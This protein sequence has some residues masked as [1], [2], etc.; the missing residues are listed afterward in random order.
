MIQPDDIRRKA[1]DLYRQYVQAWLKGDDEFFPRAIRGRKT[2]RS[3][4]LSAASRS[5]RC[6]RAGSKETVGFGYSVEWREVN[7]RRFGRNQFPVRI[8]FETPEDLLRFLDRKA[9]FDSFADAASRLR[10]DFPVLDSWIRVN[11][12]TVVELAQDLHGLLQVLHWFRDNPRP[13][14]YARELP[15]PVET[16]FIERHQRVLREWFDLVLPPHMIRSDEEHFERRY[17]L[18]YPEPHLLVRFLD[19]QLQVDMGFPCCELS[20]PLHTLAQL[21]APIG[22]VFIVENKVNLLTLPRF[23][24]AIALGGL[25]NGVTL[26]R[27]VP[28]LE[29]TPIRY[30]GDIDVEGFMILS[31][32]RAFL[33]HVQ[34]FLMDRAT[35]DRHEL[36]AVAGTGRKP[37]MPSHL[38][39]AE[40]SVFL[41]CREHNLRLE[42]ERLPQS[43]VK[44]E[45]LRNQSRLTPRT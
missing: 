22:T 26:L 20:L 11:T 38:N 36:L 30:W 43:E 15:L 13:N 34:S 33:P 16:K 29:A 14:L 37:E 23:D 8:L 24:G 1:E 18:R 4:D 10:S 42:Q 25:G 12:R 44:A 21:S 32:L 3:N 7:S 41:H 17:G 40:R 28:S 35:F 31:A 2:P 9:E 27:Y 45:M 19:P 39:D 6:L 5:V